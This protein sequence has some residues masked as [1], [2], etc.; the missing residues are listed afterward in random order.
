[1]VFDIPSDHARGDSQVSSPKVREFVQDVEIRGRSVQIH[2]FEGAYLLKTLHFD[3]YDWPAGFKEQVAFL[4][5]R[6][7][8][9]LLELSTGGEGSASFILQAQ[10][11]AINKARERLVHLL[12]FI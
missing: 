6:H 9:V 7:P 4:A 11:R 1:L 3:L 5:R 10:V 2:C 12:G 8:L